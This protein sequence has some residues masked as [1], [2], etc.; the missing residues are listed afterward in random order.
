M[1]NGIGF[2]FPISGITMKIERVGPY[3]KSFV[4][5]KTYVK[6]LLPHSKNFQIFSIVVSVISNEN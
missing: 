3:H 2:R 5:K 1:I 6:L 4:D